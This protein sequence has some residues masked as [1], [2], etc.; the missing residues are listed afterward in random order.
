LSGRGGFWRALL[1]SIVGAALVLL[2][3]E[4]LRLNATPA[5]LQAFLIAVPPIGAT[6]GFNVGR[7]ARR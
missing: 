4:P 5:V 1:G 2:A 6:L 7:K 3:A